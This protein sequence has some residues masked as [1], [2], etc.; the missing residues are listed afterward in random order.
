LVIPP[1]WSEVWIAPN[2]A[3]HLQATGRD[4][5]GRKQYRY[6]ADWTTAR[7]AAK[8]DRLI[9]A[10][11]RLAKVKVL[12]GLSKDERAV[13]RLPEI[14]RRPDDAVRRAA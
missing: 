11:P 3:A 7:D 1:A 4:A 13:L 10:W 14:A 5:R 8:F 9:V 6:H 12:A 2:P